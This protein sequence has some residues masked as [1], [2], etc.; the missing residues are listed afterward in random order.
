MYNVRFLDQAEEDMIKI[1][2]YVASDLYHPI[3]SN[4]LIEQLKES[5]NGLKEFPKQHSVYD[6][7]A[8]LE[9][10][11]REIVIG[12]Y[13]IFYFIDEVRKIVFVA[14]VMYVKQDFDIIL[15]HLKV[16]SGS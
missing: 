16:K 14:F 8:P 1:A 4:K 5:I 10:E 6:S 12:N 11:F 7:Y 13:A 3:A 15:E 2:S 9:E